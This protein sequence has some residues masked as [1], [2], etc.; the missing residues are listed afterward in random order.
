MRARNVSS[1]SGRFAVAL[2]PLLPGFPF[3]SL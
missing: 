3:Q 1:W 2:I